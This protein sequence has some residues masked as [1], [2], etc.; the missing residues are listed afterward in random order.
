MEGGH[1]NLHEFLGD[2]NCVLVTAEIDG[3]PVGQIL[4][5]ILRRWDSGK[6]MLF[7]YSIDVLGEYRK[8]GIGSELI[9]EFNRIGAEA[10]CGESFVLTEESNTAAMNLYHS[11]GGTRVFPDEVMFVWNL[12]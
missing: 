2:P 8:I 12:E 1:E 10:G 11:A 7:L 9:R 4:G 3:R 5:H 6:P